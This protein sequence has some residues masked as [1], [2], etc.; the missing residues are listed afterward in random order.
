M[1][2]RRPSR[3]GIAAG[4]SAGDV[5]GECGG[6][7]TG[8]R[9]LQSRRRPAGIASGSRDSQRATYRP[10]NVVDGK[11]EEKRSHQR[12]YLLV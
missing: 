8:L 11:R 12:A 4:Y 3:G 2:V 1:R 9:G 6:T 10:D 7:A 5:A